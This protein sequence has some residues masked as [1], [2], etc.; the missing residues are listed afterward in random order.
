MLEEKCKS[1]VDGQQHDQL[2]VKMRPVFI[3]CIVLQPPVHIQWFVLLR[4]TY[5]HKT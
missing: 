5:T 2:E 4:V 1:R 3:G